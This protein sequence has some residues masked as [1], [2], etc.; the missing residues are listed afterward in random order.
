MAKTYGRPIS[1]QRINDESELW[2]DVYKVHA[3]VNKA[4]DNNEYLQAGAIQDKRR[5]VFEIRYFKD[6]EDVALNLSYYRI[7]FGD[8]IYNIVSYDDF[9]LRHQTVK[10]LGESV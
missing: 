10:L 4:Q 3:S 7:K 2:E 5:L 8:V 1:I 6:L 9:Q